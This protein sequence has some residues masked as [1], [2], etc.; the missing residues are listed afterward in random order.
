MSIDRSDPKY[1]VCMCVP[2]VP[3]NSLIFRA[4]LSSAPL[5][6]PPNEFNHRADAL[7][8]VGTTL[9]LHTHLPLLLLRLWLLFSLLRLFFLDSLS[10]IYAYP[11]SSLCEFL[12]W[13]FDAWLNLILCV[14][15]SVVFVIFAFKSSIR[16]TSVFKKKKNIWCTEHKDAK[17]TI[18]KFMFLQISKL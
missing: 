13:Q 12:N 9:V 3:T 10:P 17:L 4:E 5:R 2:A 7:L 18:S 1:R 6:C 16:K 11:A 8:P 14:I 15:K